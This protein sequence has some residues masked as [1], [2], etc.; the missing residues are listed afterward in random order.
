MKTLITA[1][2]ILICCGSAFSQTPEEMKAWE[3]SMKPGEQHKWLASM[4]GYWNA[5]VKMWMDP[6][7][8]ATESDATTKNEMIMNGL[9]QRSSHTGDM[10]GMPFHGE[11]ITGYDNVNK[12]FVATWI[13]NMG[14]GIMYMEGTYNDA[15]KTLTL[16]GNMTDPMTGKDMKVKEKLTVKSPDTHIFEMYMVQGDQEMKTM[17]IVYTRAK[18]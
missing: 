7:Q 12:K 8:P 15:A 5:K 2:A 6:S 14:S 9:Y 13:D 10:M 3:A 4:D 1:F 18:D 17:E 11:S 16:T